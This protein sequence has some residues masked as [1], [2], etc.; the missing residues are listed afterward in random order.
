MADTTANNWKLGLFVVLGLAISAA[1]IG[2]VA[3]TQFNDRSTFVAYT[4][5]DEPVTG[6]TLDSPV[7]HRGIPIGRVAG[8]R[9]AS[10]RRRI[11]VA[12]EIDEMALVR[13]GVRTEEELSQERRVPP[14]LRSRLERSL[15]TGIAFVQTDYYDID[16][17]P[18]PDYPTDFRLQTP[19]VHSIA[20]TQATLEKLFEQL[21]EV[22]SAGKELLLQ[23]S[24]DLDEMDLP[25]LADQLT[26]TL[27]SGESVLDTADLELRNLDTTALNERMLALL[28]DGRRTLGQFEN[29]IIDLR[30]EDGELY[31]LLVRGRD[32]VRRLDEEIQQAELART[33]QRLGSAAAELGATGRDVRDALPELIN[34]M[35]SLE[36]LLTDLAADPSSLIHGRT[37]PTDPREGRGR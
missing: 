34:T 37:P 7:L 35:Q 2:W 11:E 14:D 10:D 26:Q 21:P 9:V 3:A 29:F 19:T 33:S 20:S 24:A 1:S 23:L 15:V 16:E 31:D 13:A 6:L 32:L 18:L 12:C 8:I 30:A 28:D 22:F 25:E 5:F 4:Y 36:R 27:E 17:H